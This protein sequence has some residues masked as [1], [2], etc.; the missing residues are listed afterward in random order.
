MLT[1]NK[2]FAI[3]PIDNRRTDFLCIAIGSQVGAE[4]V[5]VFLLSTE[6]DPFLLED[7][8]ISKKCKQCGKEMQTTA[9]L[10]KNGRGKFCSKTCQ[11]KWWKGKPSYKR[12]KPLTGKIVVCETCGKEFYRM[13]SELKKERGGRRYCSLECRKKSS[14]YGEHLRGEKNWSWKGGRTKLSGYIYIRSRNHPF[15]NS[16][17]YVAEHRL[18]IEKIIGRYLKPFPGEDVHHING[19]KDDNRPKN[20]RI[21]CH[22]NHYQKVRCPYCEKEF[23]VK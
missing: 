20:L 12:T 3:L 4:G 15:K 16:G 8:M 18:V 6:R 13:P 10:I 7:K 11:S 9:W 1:S 14:H 17:G 21:V 23:A 22:N 2:R 5:T 19:K